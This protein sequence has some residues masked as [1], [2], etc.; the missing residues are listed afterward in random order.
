MSN[1][2]VIPPQP[3]RSR[4]QASAELEHAHA[5]S[6]ELRRQ[7]SLLAPDEQLAPHVS[8]IMR[9]VEAS[10]LLYQV[11]RARLDNEASLGT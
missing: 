7:I 9:A 2:A 5:C 3:R 6:V 10:D 4:E 8:L 11:M 1:S